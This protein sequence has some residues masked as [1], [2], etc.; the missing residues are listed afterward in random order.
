MRT[1]RTKSFWSEASWLKYY[2]AI[3]GVSPALRLM[4]GNSAWGSDGTKDMEPPRKQVTRILEVLAIYGK[5]S[6]VSMRYITRIPKSGRHASSV[7]LKM[8]C[9]LCLCHIRSHLIPDLHSMVCI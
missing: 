1:D 5:A 6:A 8:H 7:R 9:V 3:D 2:E 4:E